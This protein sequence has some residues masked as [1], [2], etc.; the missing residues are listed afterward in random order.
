LRWHR[1]VGEQKIFQKERW[2][3]QNLA[4][5]KS[6]LGVRGKSI[7]SRKHMRYFLPRQA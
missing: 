2:E 1:G 5:W 4:Y 6:P 7:L 3:G